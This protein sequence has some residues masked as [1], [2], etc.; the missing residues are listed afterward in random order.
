[1]ERYFDNSDNISGTEI[2]TDP[3]FKIDSEFQIT[4]INL[5][6]STNIHYIFAK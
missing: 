3:I 2:N 4:S 1:M 6:V 5:R